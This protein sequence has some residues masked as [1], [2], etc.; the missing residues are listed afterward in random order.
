MVENVDGN[1][2]A[3]IIALGGILTTLITVIS[4]A[5]RTGRETDANIKAKKKQTDKDIESQAIEDELKK[6]ELNKKLIDVYDKIIEELN[7]RFE[8]FRKETL[9]KAEQ[10]KMD[11]CVEK[12]AVEKELEA[13][14]VMQKKLSKDKKVLQEAG[15]L[16]IK[17]VEK[18]LVLRDKLV[19]EGDVS[20]CSACHS[21]D[22]E[23]LRTLEEIKSLFQNG[24]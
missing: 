11:Y 12:E 19:N 7:E 17:S 6:V 14:K 13:I 9:E 16:L 4:T 2:V 20:V 18:S 10:I 24:H 21:A 5:I 1:I 8:L 22:A 23:L 3:Y 15:M